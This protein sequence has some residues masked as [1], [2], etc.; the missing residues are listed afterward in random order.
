[1]IAAVIL[2][3]GAATRMGRLKQL[4][5]Y[6]GTT[7]LQHAINQAAIAELSPIVV[8]VGSDAELV[9][10]SI[11]SAQVITVCNEAWES[12]MG[13]SIAAGIRRLQSF[14]V[15]AAAILV[16]DQPLVTAE[17]LRAMAA[18]A[19]SSKMVAAQ[20]NGALGV[21]AFFRREMFPALE[22]L[23]PEAGARHLLRNSAE[24]TAYPLPEAAIDV[25]TP[26]DLSS[27]LQT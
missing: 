1:L 15:A 20:Y 26:H 9:T 22:S 17:H 11:G 27:L 12:G 10:A 21:P 16:A 25:D 7:F 23:P 3:A 8:V 13:S 14:D 18:L 5:D 4:L 24:V 2:A 19:H 6:Q